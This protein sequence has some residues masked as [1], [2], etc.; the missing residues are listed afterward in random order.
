[1]HGAACSCPRCP[2]V[3]VLVAV[4]DKPPIQGKHSTVLL[5]KCALLHLDQLPQD[6]LQPSLRQP[7]FSS[8]PLCIEALEFN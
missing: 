8:P 2:S 3:F 5:S 4:Q 6:S 7:R 1:V